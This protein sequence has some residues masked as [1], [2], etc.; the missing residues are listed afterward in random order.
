MKKKI[1]CFFLIVLFI[2]P[3]TS[4]AF[5]PFFIGSARVMAGMRSGWTASNWARAGSAYKGFGATSGGTIG[6]AGTAVGKYTG[7]G[8]AVGVS[9]SSVMSAA[10]R[11]Y[12]NAINSPTAAAIINTGNVVILIRDILRGAGWNEKPDGSF[13]KPRGWVMCAGREVN[14]CQND[15]DFDSPAYAYDLSSDYDLDPKLNMSEVVMKMS[16]DKKISLAKEI[17]PC[18]L[19]NWNN[20]NICSKLKFKDASIHPNGRKDTVALIYEYEYEVK[21]YYGKVSKHKQDYTLYSGINAFLHYERPLTESEF[22]RIMQPYMDA[23]PTPYVNSLMRDANGNYTNDVSVV[24]VTLPTDQSI[25]SDPYTD[26]ITGE[27]HQAHYTPINDAQTGQTVKVEVEVKTRP[28][29]EPNSDVAPT[30]PQTATQTQTDAATTTTEDIEADLGEYDIPE[31]ELPEEKKELIFTTDN[32]L[33]Q[34]GECPNVKEMTILG[35]P[36]YFSW[37]PICQFA[38]MIRPLVIGISIMTSLYIV[39]GQIIRNE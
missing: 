17:D 33:P 37:V 14:N 38:L 25:V 30:L 4:Y 27:V 8:A 19:S 31:I 39:I 11:A 35:K 15:Q 26:P 23:N 22:R 24:G 7:G 36:I 20:R 32:F 10:W 13:Y 5:A 12:V 21:D 29:L 1:A 28:D 6:A 18:Y 3:Y 2:F 34:N 9:A 16:D